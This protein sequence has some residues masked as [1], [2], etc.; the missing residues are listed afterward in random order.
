M[1]E[2]LAAAR[3]RVILDRPYF[4]SAA[5]AIK[6]VEVPDM[7]KKVGSP[8]GVDKWWRLYYD[9]EVVEEWPIKVKMGI[10]THELAHLL[11]KT[12][13]RA[14]AYGINSL[15]RNLWNIAADIPINESVDADSLMELPSKEVG[16]FE[17]VR[18]RD[19]KLPAGLTTEEYYERLKKN[20]KT[21]HI[22]LNCGSGAHGQDEEHEQKGGKGRDKVLPHEAAAI[23]KAVAEAIRESKS[24]GTVPQGWKRWADSYGEA[25]V[26]WRQELAAAIRRAAGDVRG[27]VDYSYRH[28]NRRQSAFGKIVMPAMVKPEPAVSIVVDTSGSMS[29][30]DLAMA[31]SEISGILAA[32]GNR[33]AKYYAVDA[34]VHV[35]KQIQ[36][37]AQIE[38]AGGGG[39]DM[40]VGIE[41][42][43][44]DRP[45][46]DIL[47]V[48]TDGYTGWPQSAPASKLVACIVNDDQIGPS[49]AKTINIPPTAS[50]SPGGY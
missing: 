49:Y 7:M 2:G 40:C 14:L 43:M 22:K 21:I 5:W 20:A 31:A 11:R 39:T 8:A 13:D 10:F 23:G 18:A 19:F 33:T 50:S 41:R 30:D 16:G 3:A 26:N 44:Q 34:D 38:F 32:M 46:P 48:I 15:N 42:A 45:R 4:A 6:L 36:S 17:V 27:L 24:Q 9:P 37:V 1:S 47:V 35:A 28:I 12:G 25:K 29:Q